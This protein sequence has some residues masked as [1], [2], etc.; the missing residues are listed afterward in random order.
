MLLV[1]DQDGGR[2]VLAKLPLPVP[3]PGAPMIDT[4]MW[5]SVPFK[6]PTAWV[7]FVG[8]HDLWW[9]VV[10]DRIVALTG[11]P[12]RTYPLGSGGGQV[13]LAAVQQQYTHAAE[14]LGLEPPPDLQTYDLSEPG[15]FASWTWV[16]SQTARQIALATGLA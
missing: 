10:S 9:R 5:A 1:L 8:T 13:W 12:I 14:A 16:I 2:G 6:N 15:D 11:A 4:R 7:D 3:S